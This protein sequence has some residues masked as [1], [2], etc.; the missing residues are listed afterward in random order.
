M[1]DENRTKETRIVQGRHIGDCPGVA[2]AMPAMNADPRGAT[3][4]IYE[5]Y[6]VP[7]T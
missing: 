4:I 3:W 1:K 7:L 6:T 5:K 2:S